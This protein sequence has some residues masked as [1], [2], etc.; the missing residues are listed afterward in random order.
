MTNGLLEDR[1]QLEA[2]FDEL[3]R[4]LD[5]LASSAE[6]LMVGGAWML[7]NSQRMSTRDVDSARKLDSDLKKAADRV[8]ARHDLPHG[9]LNDAAA[10][11]WPSTAS[12]EECELVYQH[13]AL[14]VRSPSANVIFLMKLYRADP[15]DREDLVTLWPLCDFNQADHAARAFRLAYPQAPEDEHLVNYI[16]DVAGDAIR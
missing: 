2:L 3:A 15:Q 6:I 4:E 16:A 13:P 11:F 8:A 10:P 12:Y 5:Q 1:G 7:W 9:W 14:E